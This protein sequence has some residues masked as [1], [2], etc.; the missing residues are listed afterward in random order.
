M[1]EMDK[2][3]H[4]GLCIPIPQIAVL[5]ECISK[6]QANNFAQQCRH[7]H[8]MQTICVLK[9]T[10]NYILVTAKHLWP[11]R[12]DFSLIK[13]RHCARKNCAIHSCLKA[14]MVVGR[15]RCA[16]AY[17]SSVFILICGW[18]WPYVSTSRLSVPSLFQVSNYYFAG[19][20]T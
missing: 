11:S 19:L 17:V 16:L 1:V 10:T 8:T 20:L 9:K 12:R 2:M 15:W 5:L 4:N 13:R 14:Q 7:L 3:V 6:K 18:P